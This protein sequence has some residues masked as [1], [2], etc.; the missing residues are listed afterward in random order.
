M[1]SLFTTSLLTSPR[2]KSGPSPFLWIPAFAGM[3]AG[4]LTACSK[5]K[6]APK[7]EAFPVN[8]QAVTA[9]TLEDTLT[10]VGSL[11]ARDEATLYSRVPG[12][13]QENLLHE[14]QRVEKNQAVALVLK[15]EVGV[16]YEPAPVPSTLTG[17]VARMYLDRGANVTLDTPIAL[18]MDDR[19]LI[20]KADIP[21]RYAGRIVLG[22]DVRVQVDAYPNESFRGR[23][24]RVSPAVDPET[25]TAPIEVRLEEH[26]GKLRSGMFAKLILVR[27]RKTGVLLVPASALTADTP[28]AVFVMENGK[29]VKKSVELGLRTDAAAEVRQGLL[30]GAQVITS[31]LFGI[32]DGSPVEVAP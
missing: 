13:L 27:D 31:G 21:E 7:L 22:Q 23:V 28:P 5:P 26:Q 19:E 16:K 6:E 32:E 20:A 2:R 18:V 8:V 10:L 3:T 25:R 14:G 15:D 30:V 11:K 12:K 1:K 9:G 24:S 4:I 17:I 29:A